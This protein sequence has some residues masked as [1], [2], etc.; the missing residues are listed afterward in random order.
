MMGSPQKDGFLKI[1]NEI[2]E[3]LAKLNLSSYEWRTLWVLWR[4]T[5]GW[6]KEIDKISITQF[7]KATGLKRRHQARALK[8]LIDKNIV[9]YIGNSYIH[10]Y[11]FQKDYAK[12]K[13]VT[14][15]GNDSKTVT[16]IGNSPLPVKVTGSLPLKVP[17]KDNKETIQ[18]KESA[19][20][21]IRTIIEE[22]KRLKGY[23][24]QPDWDKNYYVKHTRA[25]K[26]LYKIAGEEWQKAMEWV[27][28]RD[29][30]DWT[31]ETVIK[32]FPDF[33]KPQY[34]KP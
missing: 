1:N 19:L 6:Q 26:E 27:S 7:Q 10:N 21:F 8:A 11:S 15:K 17:T 34:I 5:L 29:Y 9:T 16:Y 24:K 31:L 14:C 28:K 4:K 25:A 30:C 12:W 23:D 2:A 22:Y 3:Q 13:T 20:T 33:K 32:K 18:K